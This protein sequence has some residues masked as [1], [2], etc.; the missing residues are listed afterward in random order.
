MS[1]ATFCSFSASFSLTQGLQLAGTR[2][3]ADRGS[4]GGFGTCHVAARGGE[5]GGP[6]HQPAQGGRGQ[7]C[8]SFQQPANDQLGSGRNVFDSKVLLLLD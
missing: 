4:Q 7:V 5:P 2:E 1:V 8:V 3:L 6:L